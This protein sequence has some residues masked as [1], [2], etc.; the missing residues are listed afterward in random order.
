MTEAALTDQVAGFREFNRFYTNE[1]GLLRRGLLDTP[2]SLTEGRVLYE[3]AQAEVIETKELRERLDVDRGYLSRI[4]ARFERDGLLRRGRSGADARV[5]TL[6]LTAKGRKLVAGL[7]KRSSARAG[8]RL[9]PLEAADRSRLL[10]AMGTIR[11][12]LDPAARGS[13]FELREPGVGDL[14]W[15]VARHGTVY[16]ES[17][18][19]DA[20]FEALVAGVVGRF[21]ADHD[22][23]RER[24][25][26]ATVEGRRAGSIFCVAE[27]DETARLR[28]LLVE[29]S[30]R[31]LGIG[32][33]LVEACVEFARA[34]GYRR[35][36]L[37]TDDFLTAARRLYATAGFVLVSAKTEVA[38][39]QESVA[40]DWE[41][42]F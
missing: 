21:A 41:L 25:W 39:G 8:E 32:G 35:M 14:G 16:N 40:E 38:F 31:G 1:I 2:W 22:P 30:A 33:T 18:G 10:E 26:I 5:Q 7:D 9:E 19:F 23:A 13:D 24:G 28:L 29:P 42:V 20:S 6:K 15:V 11:A 17:Y 3:L 4:L 34:A 27:D 36:V 12:V 37:W